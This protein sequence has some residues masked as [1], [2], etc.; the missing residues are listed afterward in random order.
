[1]AGSDAWKVARRELR[2][3]SPSRR[4]VA[5]AAG[6]PQLIWQ[7]AVQAAGGAGARR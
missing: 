6:A 1:L 5:R 2:R 4:L 7:R 3:R